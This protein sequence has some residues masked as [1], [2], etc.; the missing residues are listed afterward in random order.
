MKTI[1][2]LRNGDTIGVAVQQDD[3]PMIQFLLNGEPLHDLNISRFRGVV[4]PSVLLVGDDN[5]GKN[6]TGKL[7]NVKFV[8]KEE[9]FQEMSPSVRFKPLMAAISIV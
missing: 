7:D 6:N 9:E 1:T 5:D 4:Y 8:W 2:N 3:L